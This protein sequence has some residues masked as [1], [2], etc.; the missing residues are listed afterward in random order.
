MTARLLLRERRILTEDR[1]AE[2]VIWL[3]RRPTEGCLHPFKYWMTF[4]V[5]GMCVLR[6]TTKP[7][8]GITSIWEE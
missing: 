1:F 2:I 7:E 8:R 4:V 5:D 3:L 6:S